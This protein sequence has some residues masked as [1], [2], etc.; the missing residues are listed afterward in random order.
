MQFVMDFVK[1]IDKIRGCLAGGAAGDALGYAVEFD[2]YERIKAMY[3]PEG[4]QNYFPDRSTGLALI[5]D[6]TQMTLFTAE[7]LLKCPDVRAEAVDYLEH[8]Y[9]AWYSTQGGVTAVPQWSAFA[10]NA[11]LKALR[12]P[13]NTCLSALLQLSQGR[14]PSN[15]SKGCGGV[16]RVA[17][18]ALYGVASGCLG[19]SEVARLSADAAK[20]THLH[21]LGYIPADFLGRVLFDVMSYECPGD[22]EEKAAVLSRFA[23]YAC[24]ALENDYSDNKADVELFISLIKRALELAV[25]DDADETN[26]RRLG[27][28]W[29]AEETVAIALYCAVRYADDFDAAVRAAVNHDGDS[30]ST[31][32]VCGNII[33]A[34]VGYDAIPQKYKENLELLPVLIDTAD[35]LAATRFACR[36]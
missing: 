18:V 2:S 36:D 17:P 21:P 35:R 8:G 9:L 33:G 7:A 11:R 20:I 25:N 22:R 23:V 15:N 32:A 16:M 10:H 28:G 5:S 13:G 1:L 6:D 34:L 29:V 14:R 12:A 4:I 24:H 31:G 27:E 3:G 19:E 26:I 30:D